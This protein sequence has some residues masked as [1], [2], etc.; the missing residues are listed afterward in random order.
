MLRYS[1]AHPYAVGRPTSHVELGPDLG[2][3]D[4]RIL[5][6]VA[7]KRVVDLGCGMG[8]AAVA[9]AAMGAKVIAVDNDPTQLAHAR[10]LAE[11]EE[12]RVELHRAD[13]A[14]LAFLTSASIDLVVSVYSLAAVDDLDRVF[15]QVHR[16]LHPGAAF[17]MS[18][19]HPFSM[20]VDHHVTGG[21]QVTHRLDDRRPRA[22]GALV[23]YP[24]QIGE[25]FASLTRANF[26]IDTLLEPMP[27]VS[28]DRAWRPELSRWLPSTL[29]VRS[30][31]EGI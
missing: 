5:G 21:L 27:Q 16:V 22:D 2:R 7:G 4:R 14:E 28:G 15:R 18:L 12:V 29:I 11:H 3:V 1:T 17:V 24:H 25:L 10:E 9:L 26:R 19:P 31:K 13:L 8:H 30:R 6:E 23:T 20:L